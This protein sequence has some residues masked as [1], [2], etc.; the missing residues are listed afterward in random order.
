VLSQTGQIKAGVPQGAVISPILFSIFINDIPVNNKPNNSYSL[1]FADDLVSINC[2]KKNKKIAALL[3]RYLKRIEVWLCKWKMSMSASKC[4]FTVFSKGKSS[5][6]A[7][8]IVLK[9]HGQNI[10]YEKNPCFLGITF[11][12]RL[13]FKKHIEKVREKCIKRLNI[14]K[15][16]SHKSWKLSH[17]TLISI[18]YCLARSIVDYC[19]TFSSLIYKTNLTLLQRIQNQAIKCIFKPPLNTNLTTFGRA[20]NIDEISLRLNNLMYRYIVN[21]IINKN[22]LIEILLK[23]YSE[24][25]K[26]RPDIDKTSLSSVKS[27]I[28]AKF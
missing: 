6:S 21:C 11:D 17:H 18:Y 14:L 5:N 24:G 2:F 28:F 15:I 22:P 19:F 3:A 20:H 9:L 25:F 10:P 8:P 23:E 27:I 1:L 7:N 26:S 16:I 13:T 4:C 12:E